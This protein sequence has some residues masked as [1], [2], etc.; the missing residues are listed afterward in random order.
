MK[1]KLA[2]IT[3]ESLVDGPGIRYVIFS[4]GCNHNCK[5]CHNP[6][7]HSFDKGKEFDV[8]E[9]LQDILNRKHIDGV[10]FSGGD[11]FYQPEEFGY[12]AKR[13][14]EENIHIISYTG[15][16]Y[17]NIL[18]NYKM[19]E[20]LENVDILIDGPFIENKKTFKMAF[21][22]SENQRAI[23]VKKSLLDDKVITLDL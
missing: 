11:P 15:F 5:G 2:G 6:S 19:K 12:I 4:Q 7:T 8:E 10:T 17:E 21:R 9:I 1:V 23:D 14:R 16:K 3:K 18:D 22:G 20:L 13:L